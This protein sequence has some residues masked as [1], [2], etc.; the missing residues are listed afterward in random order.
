MEYLSSIAERV[1]HHLNEE[2]NVNKQLTRFM[3]LEESVITNTT[4]KILFSNA[5]KDKIVCLLNTHPLDMPWSFR[6]KINIEPALEC[7]LHKWKQEKAKGNE[8]AYEVYPNLLK[9]PEG[10]GNELVKL[11]SA[12]VVS[13]FKEIES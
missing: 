9:D 12:D 4:V 5:K 3:S 1:I 10:K 2:L 7:E 6:I 11:I 8:I 13:F